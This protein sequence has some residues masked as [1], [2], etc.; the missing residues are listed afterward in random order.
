[1]GRDNWTTDHRKWTAEP[2][3]N[4]EAETSGSSIKLILNHYWR[5]RFVELKE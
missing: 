3:N 1:M 5:R 2:Q 4:T